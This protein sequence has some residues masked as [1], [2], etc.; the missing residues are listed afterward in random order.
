VIVT[1]FNED[2][3]LNAYELSAELR[4]GGLKVATYPTPAKLGKQFK[5][6]DRIGAKIAIV[7]GPDEI[8][9]DQIVIK[10]LQTGNQESVQRNRAV[11]TLVLMLAPYNSP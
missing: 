3:L 11:E 9:I 10:D 7:I 2:L 5:Y 6:A 8:K 1:V 4:K